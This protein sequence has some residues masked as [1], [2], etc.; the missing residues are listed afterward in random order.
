MEIDQEIIDDD[1]ILLRPPFYKVYEKNPFDRPT[2]FSNID[3]IYKTI[4]NGFY[5]FEIPEGYKIEL[6]ENNKLNLLDGIEF[7]YIVSK[8]AKEVS[9]IHQLRF[10]ETVF[11]PT[12]Y[13]ALKSFVDDMI[14]SNNQYIVL[15][16]SI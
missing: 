16:R 8:N 9:I 3:F 15:K 4:I 12:D 13:K 10:D 5:T 14:I 7:N 1:L 6:P 11:L 2:R